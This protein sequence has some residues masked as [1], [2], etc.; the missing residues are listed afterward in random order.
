[1]SKEKILFIF[2]IIF[3]IFV[4]SVIVYFF[5][6]TGEKTIK[7]I[8][9][10]GEESW[11]IGQIHEITWE[12]KNIDKVGIV[13]F[14]GEET[15]WIAKDIKAIAGKYDWEIYPGHK[16]GRGFWIAIFEYPWKEDGKVDYVDGSFSI[17]FPVLAG[18]DNLSIDNEWPYLASDLPEV[19]KVFLTKNSY[20]GDLAGLSGADGICQKEASDLE[21]KGSWVAFLGGDADKET[22]LER[23]KETERGQEGIF[24]EAVSSAVLLRGATCHRLLGKTLNEFLAKF[25]DM[26]IINNEKI[27]KEFM[28]EMKN[29]WLGRIDKTSKKSCVVAGKDS[30]RIQ[31]NYSSTTTCQNWTKAEQFVEEGD[32]P[33][34]YTPSGILTNA[35]ASGGLALGIE[36]KAELATYNP[37]LGGYCSLR[38]KLLCI[39][40]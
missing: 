1:M 39:E 29:V 14:N 24:V 18:C 36:G 38:K 5:I 21:Y 3:A 31:E 2:L 40:E 15:E 12:S 32:Y 6:S 20:T 23:I 11:E 37:E 28:E 7:V 16:Y 13:L 8:T 35:V 10:N 22:A 17:T 25:S 26:F 19:R 4:V 34:C 9:P 30:S 33:T 27:S